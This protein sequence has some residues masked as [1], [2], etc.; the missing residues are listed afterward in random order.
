MGDYKYDTQIYT[1]C[2]LYIRIIHMDILRVDSWAIH[3]VLLASSNVS[4]KLGV[5]CWSAVSQG[6]LRPLGRSHWDLTWCLFLCWVVMKTLKRW[7]ST[8]K[9][10]GSPKI[11]A[12]H[13]IFAASFTCDLCEFWGRLLSLQHLRGKPPWQSV[14]N[15]C[16]RLC[17]CTHGQ[18][19]QRD[20]TFLNISVEWSAVWSSHDHSRAT[21]WHSVAYG[22]DSWFLPEWPLELPSIAVTGWPAWPA[23]RCGSAVLRRLLPLTAL[24]HAQPMGWCAQLGQRAAPKATFLYC[25][26]QLT[27]LGLSIFSVRNIQERHVLQRGV[28]IGR[29]MIAQNF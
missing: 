29:L 23:S 9:I 21:Q 14:D 28:H 19:I 6:V 7:H 18:I 20:Q 5:A 1:V 17:L 3:H 2:T 16:L 22:L 26:R 11:S 24:R 10:M 8:W 25:D 13:L 15:Q 4:V 27:V 12:G